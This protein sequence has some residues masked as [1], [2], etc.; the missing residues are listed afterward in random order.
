MDGWEN[1]STRVPF[2]DTNPENLFIM[3]FCTNELT[4]CSSVPKDVPWSGNYVSHFCRYLHTCVFLLL[5]VTGLRTM[6][7]TPHITKRFR[8]LPNSLLAEF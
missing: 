5:L 8:Y 4:C 2:S 6:M 7:L 3:L 1:D